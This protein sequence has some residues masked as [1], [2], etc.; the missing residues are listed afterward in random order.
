MRKKKN[1]I[2]IPVEQIFNPYIDTQLWYYIPGF[3]GYEISDRGVVRS[4]KHFKKYPYGVLLHGKVLDNNDCIFT[5]SD[6]NNKR[7]QITRNTL[8]A[9]AINNKNP[10]AGY[11]RRTYQ[12]DIASR[13]QQIFIHRETNNQGEKLFTPQFT[14]IK[15]ELETPIFFENNIQ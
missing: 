2:M 13:N 8:W 15:E 1:T 11:P 4:M 3:N 10:V 6:N 7:V 14:T 9:L 5:L 12:T